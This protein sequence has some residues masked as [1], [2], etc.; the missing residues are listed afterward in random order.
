MDETQLVFH[1]GC[2]AASCVGSRHDSPE[3]TDITVIGIVEVYNLRR[4][5][6]HNCQGGGFVHTS[7]VTDTFDAL[8][9][10]IN[11]TGLLDLSRSNRIFKVHQGVCHVSLSQTMLS[12]WSLYFYCY[13]LG[14]CS[15][16]ITVTFLL[17]RLCSCYITVTFLLA[18]D[19]LLRK[20]TGGKT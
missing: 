2:D 13:I 7:R 11:V 20:A 19:S 1:C 16:Y 10:N 5:Y 3:V 6:L 8:C 18:N 17:L 14:L 12:C 15:C 4:V 9:C